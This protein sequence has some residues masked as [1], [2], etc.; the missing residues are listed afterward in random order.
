M[1]S[2]TAKYGMK[3]VMYMALHFETNRKFTVLELSEKLDVPKYFLSKIL[4]DLTKNN[5]VSSQKGPK[6]GF[7]L[8]ESQLHE[9]PYVFM[10]SLD[11]E[12]LW[13][14]C[15]FESK[16][17]EPGKPCIFHHIFS[18][19]KENLVRDFSSQSLLDFVK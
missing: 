4:Y 16:P 9:N 1:L 17:C 13:N 6:G 8:S 15:L 7:F 5:L 11:G 2:K 3:A 10:K 19:Y 12:K 14:Y 18:E